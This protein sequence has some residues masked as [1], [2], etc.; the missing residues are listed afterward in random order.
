MHNCTKEDACMPHAAIF[1][2]AN[3]RLVQ[4]AALCRDWSAR[5]FFERNEAPVLQPRS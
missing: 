1:E 2:E 3:C 5:L 4:N